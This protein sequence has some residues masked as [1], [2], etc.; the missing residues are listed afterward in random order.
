MLRETLKL[1]FDVEKAIMEAQSFVSDTSLEDFLESQLGSFP[2]ACG[3]LILAIHRAPKPDCV[4][5]SLKG[6]VGRV[7]LT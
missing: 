4:L 6:V 1:L 3:A 5:R 2:A 7:E